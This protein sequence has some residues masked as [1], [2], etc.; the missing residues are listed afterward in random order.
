MKIDDAADLF[1]NMTAVLRIVISDETVLQRAAL[2]A[3]EEALKFTA[4]KVNERLDTV[5][6][7]IPVREANDASAL[8]R[9]ALAARRAT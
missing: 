3:T 4:T 5:R 1:D 7:A 9:Q 2:A 6:A 8:L